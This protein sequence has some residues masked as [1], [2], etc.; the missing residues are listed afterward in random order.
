MGTTEVLKQNTCYTYLINNNTVTIV[1]YNASCGSDVVIPSTID[2]NSVTT[3]GSH[4]F[5]NN[6]LTSVT[7]PNSVTAIGD[8]AFMF[9]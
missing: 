9:N 6:Q 1:D 7:V 4:A 2:G 8:G 5:E 3:I